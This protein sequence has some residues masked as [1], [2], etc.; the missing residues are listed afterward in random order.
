MNKWWSQYEKETD[1]LLLRSNVHSCRVQKGSKVSTNMVSNTSAKMVSDNHGP[2]GCLNKDGICMARFPRDI[3]SETVVDPNDGNIS[4]KKNEAWL[5]TFT[6]L[7]T[8][9]LRFNTDVSSLNSGTSVKSIILYVTDYITKVSLKSHHIFSNALDIYQKNSDLLV[10]SGSTNDAARKMLLRI[11]NSLTAKIEVG[12]PMACMYLL[13]HPDHYTSHHFVPVFWK[14]YV[15]RVRAVW[16]KHDKDVHNITDD[17]TEADQCDERMLL[18][19]DPKGDVAVMSKVDDY[20]HRPP[21]LDSMALYDWVSHC[22]NVTM[23]KH[24]RNNQVPSGD[25]LSEEANDQDGYNS[26]EEEDNGVGNALHD[27]I[28]AMKHCLRFKSSHPQYK[29]HWVRCHFLHGKVSVPNFLGGSLPRSD[30]GD[31]EFYCITMLTLFKPWISGIDLK[32]DLQLWNDAF[33]EYKFSNYFTTLMC[34]FNSKFECLDAKDDYR[35]QLKRKESEVRRL[36]GLTGYS[37]YSDE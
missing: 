17:N 19:V 36:H 28:A 20:M 34:N 9:L 30:Q 37:E 7:L 12:S 31:R 23:P 14:Q 5:N 10:D 16:Y 25:I 22:E 15:Y 26:E 32:L 29:T 24:R 13:G 3:V 8:Y 6:P 18:S 21:E 27:N 35:A 1:A 33:N 2:K 4:V 11:G